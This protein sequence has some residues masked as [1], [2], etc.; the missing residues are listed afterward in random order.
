MD[1]CCICEESVTEPASL[2]HADDDH[3]ACDSCRQAYLEDADHECSYFG[4]LI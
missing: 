1:I 2:S 3:C 4:G